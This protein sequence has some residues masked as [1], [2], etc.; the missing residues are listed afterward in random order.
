MSGR[1]PVPC[2]DSAASFDLD[3]TSA[4]FD[5]PEAVAA[6]ETFDLFATDA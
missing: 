5:D 1:A 2:F 3:T 6:H 4:P